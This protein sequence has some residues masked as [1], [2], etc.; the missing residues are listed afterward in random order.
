MNLAVRGTPVTW[1]NAETRQ[2]DVAMLEL[3]VAQR[4]RVARTAKRLIDVVSAL[5]GLLIAAPLILVVAPLIRLDSSGP[6]FF[7]QRRIGLGG[8][9][10]TILKLRSM[11]ADGRVTRMGR[12]LR[13]MGID[14]LPQLWHVLTGEMSLVGPRP[15]VP[16]IV[17]RWEQE[18]HSYGARH[19]V[20]P[21]ITGWAQVNGL[22]GD[23]S[24][25]E[26]LRFD[27]QYVRE[28]SLTMDWRI[29]LKSIPTVWRDT[30]RALGS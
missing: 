16:H 22:R 23:V 18:L 30:R 26:R 3:V 2:V 14:E 6:V 12:F 17:R 9:P 13:P 5:L 25:A 19:I 24:I 28:W 11:H 4:S 15:E 8:H 7:R 29:L 1:R 20:C 27:L 10:F 21:G